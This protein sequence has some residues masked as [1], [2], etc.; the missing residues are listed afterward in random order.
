MLEIRKNVF[1]ALCRTLP[2]LFVPALII[3]NPLAANAADLSAYTTIYSVKQKDSS[4]YEYS[5]NYYATNSFGGQNCV[6]TKIRKINNLDGSIN[7]GPTLL[8]GGESDVLIG[9]FRAHNYGKV[10]S[11]DVRYTGDDS[12]Y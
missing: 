4:G 8:D 6:Y 12:C 2:Q 11:I 10:W 9:S 5:V 7:P 3:F 1:A